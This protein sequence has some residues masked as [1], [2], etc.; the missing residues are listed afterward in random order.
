MEMGIALIFIVIAG[1]LGILLIKEKK[2]YKKCIEEYSEI[3]DIKKEVEKTKL[4]QKKIEE[5]IAN[6]KVN[7]KEEKRQN[8]NKVDALKIDYKEK[9]RIYNNLKKEIALYDEEIELIEL[10]LYKPYF[11]FDT[12]E[13]YKQELQEIR[14]KQRKMLSDK[15]AIFCSQEWV[16][17]GS[18]SKGKA[19]MNRGIR[20]TSRAFNNECDVL[21]SKV[22]WNNVQ[23]IEERIKKSYEAINKLNE[24]TAIQ[25]DTDYLRFKLV[26][27]RLAYEYKE[28]KQEEK[29]EQA[30]IRQQMR[31]ELKLEQEAQKALK[32]E[33]KYQ[34]LLE[35]AKS[36]VEKA[37]GEK[38]LLLNEKIEILNQDLFEA[39][40]KNQRAK[41]MAQQTRAGHV[42][43][44]SNIGSFGDDIYK[45]GMT[46][47]LEPL[48]RVKELGD[49]SVPFIF[50]VHA[51][52]YS[53]DA[54]SLEKKLHKVFK[55]KRVN[56][57]NNRKEFFNITLNDI[58]QEVKK[59]FSN[60]EFIKTIEAREYHESKLIRI[61]NKE[62]IV[63]T[64]IFPEDI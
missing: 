7:Y 1:L 52:I 56:L 21:I 35:K 26:E 17:E 53:E 49:A 33:D 25:I 10:G 20:L 32:E 46:R 57:V 22:T 60:I 42:Y 43:V 19:M 27:L 41:S 30:E 34:K 18:K 45:I 23:K 63:E 55:D 44:I 11:D 15:T 8:S 14:E 2:Q 54:P 40:E 16:V 3:K 37:T 12:S 39:H 6:L 4:E 13:K 58:E 31:E 9:M 24:S 48:D 36:D 47:R 28:K 51:L 59:S 38:L 5:K 61:K 64:N 50:D 29:E 62:S